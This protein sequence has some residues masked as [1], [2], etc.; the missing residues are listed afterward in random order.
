MVTMASSARSSIA[1]F[2]A[3]A[4]TLCLRDLSGSDVASDDQITPAPLLN[5]GIDRHFGLNHFSIQSKQLYFKRGS[6]LAG[7]GNRLE[8][9]LSGGTGIRVN[10]IQHAPPDEVFRFFRAQEFEAGAIDK[11]N[12]SVV[13]RE[14]G[15]ET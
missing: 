14:N 5:D 11:G 1:L 6:R 2:R 9:A 12:D 15:I 8:L 7:I 10:K 4:F 13:M 3:L